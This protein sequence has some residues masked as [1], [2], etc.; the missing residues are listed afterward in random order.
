[1]ARTD[2]KHERLAAIPLFSR[3]D[4]K[5]LE[6]LAAAA[7][8]IDVP[9]GHVLIN[10]GRTH[11]ELFVLASGAASVSIDGNQVAALQPGA[12]FGELA[13][14]E[15]VPATATV[16]TTEASSIMLIPYNRTDQILDD[17]PAFVRGIAAQLAHRLRATDEL[18]RGAG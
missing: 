15:R 12:V 18:L 17:N 13:M 10:Q 3:A 14:F 6:H 8:E 5:A 2:P 9:A 1:M 11:S 4:R 16:T 7:E